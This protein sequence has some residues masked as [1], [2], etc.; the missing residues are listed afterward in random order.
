MTN[1]ASTQ[2]SSRSFRLSTRSLPAF[3]RP[4]RSNSV[5]A[6]SGKSPPHQRDAH[7]PAFFR[8]C[9]NGYGNANQATGGT[10][11][12]NSGGYLY[13]YLPRGR[14]QAESVHRQGQCEIEPL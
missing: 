3:T 4:T 9:T 1:L 5:Q 2:G 11:Q 6:S 7:L 8:R 14:L 12:T 10:P 13:D